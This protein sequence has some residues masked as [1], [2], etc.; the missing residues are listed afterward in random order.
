MDFDFRDLKTFG[1]LS[2]PVISPIINS[3]I[4]P[5]LERPNN[6]VLKKDKQQKV[7]DNF[8]ENK[9]TKYLELIYRDSL[10]LTTLVFPNSQT[11]IKDLYCL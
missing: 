1:E 7:E 9:F 5:H 3:L 10:Y 2:K 8:W 11:K 6:W 4:K